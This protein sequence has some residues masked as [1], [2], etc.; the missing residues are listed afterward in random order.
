M[1]SL[2]T[3]MLLSVCIVPGE[4]Y[5]LTF[6]PSSSKHTATSSK[7]RRYLRVTYNTQKKML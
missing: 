1:V 7:T 5:S 2:L 3:M 4:W 6:T